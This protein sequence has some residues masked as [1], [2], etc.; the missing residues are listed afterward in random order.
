M[1]IETNH[2]KLIPCDTEIL[3]SAIQGNTF[4]AQI[5]NVT[6]PDN[7]TEFGIGPLQF[8]MDK[9]SESED[10][11]GWLTYLPIHKQDNKLIGNGGYKGKPTTDGTVE[12]GYE[13]VPTY[14][15]R[16]LAS[17]MTKGLIQNAFKDHRVKSII[18][19]TL[20]EENPSTRILKKFGFEMVQEINDP[21]DGLIWRWEL[22]RP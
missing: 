3:N 6:V 22:K 1:L 9:L 13:I 15:N 17:E 14:R 12:L 2:L 21:D 19:H 11:K 4:L 16:G 20:R 5:L 10:E 18:A 8:S 7:W